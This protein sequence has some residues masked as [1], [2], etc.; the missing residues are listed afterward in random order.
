MRSPGAGAE[1]IAG[2]EVGLRQIG[3]EE[4]EVTRHAV[5]SREMSASC[6][7]R[8]ARAGAGGEK[9]HIETTIESR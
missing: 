3:Y 6:A 2:I 9:S 4:V 1:A 7:W 8:R 5:G